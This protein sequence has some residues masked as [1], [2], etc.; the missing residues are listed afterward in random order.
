MEA[1]WSQSPELE[2]V[3]ALSLARSTSE[4]A[5]RAIR[6]TIDF[7]T[8]SSQAFWMRWKH[9]C[10]GAENEREVHA[11]A[12]E[13]LIIFLLLLLICSPTSTKLAGM[14]INIWLIAV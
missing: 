7:M 4:L 8:G 12:A 6:S 9:G 11:S 5:D 2:A 10:G 13:F 3:A 14:K 1:E